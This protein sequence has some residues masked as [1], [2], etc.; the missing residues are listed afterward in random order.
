LVW[1][2][3]WDSKPP[4]WWH[5]LTCGAIILKSGIILII[6]ERCSFQLS[7]VAFQIIW[8]CS[9][10]QSSSSTLNVCLQS[11][12]HKGLQYADAQLDIETNIRFC[13]ILTGNL[14]LDYITSVPSL[15]LGSDIGPQQKTDKPK[16]RLTCFTQGASTSGP[17]K[18][19]CESTCIPIIWIPITYKWLGKGQDRKVGVGWNRSW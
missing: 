19:L 16:L 7:L 11:S 9:A 2:S 3:V 17:K 13:G 18:C 1:L 6:L 15:G 5:H 10:S 4:A 12:R 8:H 14:R